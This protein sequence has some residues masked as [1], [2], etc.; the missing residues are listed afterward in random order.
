MGID[1]SR[2]EGPIIPVVYKINLRDPSA[3]FLATRF[4]MRNKDVL[5]V[6]NATTVEIAKVLEFLRLIT[7]TANDPIVAATS[8]YSL[9]AAISGASPTSINVVP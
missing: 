1:I 4:Q 6:S 5:Y 7:A 3:Y 8:A 9:K 2:F